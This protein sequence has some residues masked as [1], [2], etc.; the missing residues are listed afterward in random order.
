MDENNLI[1]LQFFGFLVGLAALVMRTAE[2]EPLVI[3]FGDQFHLRM[4]I[5]SIVHG[6][7]ERQDPFAG[8]LVLIFFGVLLP[9][10]N[11]SLLGFVSGSFLQAARIYFFISV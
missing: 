10:M 11:V 1:M 3:R 9:E 5:A 7:S 6:T 8:S 2:F 4:A